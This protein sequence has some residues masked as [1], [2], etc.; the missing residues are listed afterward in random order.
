[1]SAKLDRLTEG[2]TLQNMPSDK[3]KELEFSMHPSMLSN[4]SQHRKIKNMQYEIMKYQK[5]ITLLKIK[6]QFKKLIM[7]RKR[8]KQTEGDG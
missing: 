5:E 7:E 4:T 6:L 3:D 1:M 2:L 8:V